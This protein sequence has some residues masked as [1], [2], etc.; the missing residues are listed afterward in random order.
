MSPLRGH[1]GKEQGAAQGRSE[2]IGALV[3]PR[4]VSRLWLLT[5]GVSLRALELEAELGDGA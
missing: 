1:W 4:P 5:S 2:G 3:T